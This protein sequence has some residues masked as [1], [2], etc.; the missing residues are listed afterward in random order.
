MHRKLGDVF[1]AG[2]AGGDGGDGVGCLRHKRFDDPIGPPNR[3]L[4]LEPKPPPYSVSPITCPSGSAT[5]PSQALPSGLKRG[6]ITEP[7]RATA[8][9]IVALTS[10][11]RT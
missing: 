3:D 5:S 6:M 8:L 7:P 4:N 9:S 2:A 11:T 1:G 10:A